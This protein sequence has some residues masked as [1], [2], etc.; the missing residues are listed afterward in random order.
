MDWNV[1]CK[2]V[3]D[4]MK[5]HTRP[6]TS[7]LSNETEKHVQLQGTGTY[8]QFAGGRALFTCEHVSRKAPLNA[9]VYGSEDVLALKTPFK[10]SRTRDLAYTPIDD[11]FWV[12][13][14][15]KAQCIPFDRFAAQHDPR[16]ESELLFFRGFAGENSEYGFGMLDSIASAYLTQQVKTDVEDAEIFELFWEPLKTELTDVPPT[17]DFKTDD[18]GGFSG[19]LVWNTRFMECQRAN[20]EW[21]PERAVVTGMIRRWDTKS[22]TLLALRIE[23]VNHWLAGFL[24][25]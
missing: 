9:G 15:H 4:E 8:V 19:S 13:T 17:P 14:V 7:P 6:F 16:H 25:P 12:A 20:L 24:R 21:S 3:T 10:E 1:I 11:G 2:M 18:P 5:A 22:K 23:H